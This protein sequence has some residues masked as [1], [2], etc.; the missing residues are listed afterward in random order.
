M[1]DIKDYMKPC[2][3]E[4]IG[5]HDKGYKPMECQECIR[6]LN[7]VLLMV[8]PLPDMGVAKNQ[9]ASIGRTLKYVNDMTLQEIFIYQKMV[10]AIAAQASLIYN[11]RLVRDKIVD[12]KELE[13]RSEDWQQAQKEMQVRNLPKVS[14]KHLT[15]YEKAVQALMH[16]GLSRIDAESSVKER[17]DAQNKMTG[18]IFAK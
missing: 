5:Q 14:K 13:K 16:I 4:S 6:H 8:K 11:Q 9:E 17:F 3:N 12:P 7:F 10:E 1:I 2:E 15:D 18:D